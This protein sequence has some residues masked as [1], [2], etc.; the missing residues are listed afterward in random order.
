MAYISRNR[1]NNLPGTRGPA[2]QVNSDRLTFFCVFFVKSYSW[3]LSKH[4]GLFFQ[5]RNLKKTTHDLKVFTV[6]CGMFKKL[7]V[8][9]FVCFVPFL[10]CTL[11]TVCFSRIV[12]PTLLKFYCDFAVSCIFLD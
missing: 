1:P 8:L 2:T 7:N 10:L 3:P 9:F 11:D 4:V 12:T 6:I 5:R